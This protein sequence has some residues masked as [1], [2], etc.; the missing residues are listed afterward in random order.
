MY[1]DE[2]FLPYRTQVHTELYSVADAFFVC[3]CVCFG[4]WLCFFCL[5]FT[6][7]PPH[8]CAFKIYVNSV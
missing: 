8:F 7:R 6:V 1:V 3:D 5:K 4:G 2:A